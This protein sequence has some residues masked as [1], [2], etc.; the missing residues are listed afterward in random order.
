MKL[1]D[2]ISLAPQ[3]FRT[4]IN[5]AG[6][7]HRFGKFQVG[8]QRYCFTVTFLALCI[9]KVVH[10]F[11][12]RHSLTPDKFLIW[13]AT[14]FIQDALVII[15][16]RVLAQNFRRRW[17]QISTTV[18]AI[19]LRYVAET[20]FV[21]RVWNLTY[22]YS[23]PISGMASANTSFFVATGAEIHWRRVHYFHRDAAA[24]RTLLTGLAGFLFVECFIL[25]ISWFLAS[26][27]YNGMGYVLEILGS[28]LRPVLCCFRSKPVRNS[29]AYGPIP[30][31][32]YDD[33]LVEEEGSLFLLDETNG[34]PNN[35]PKSPADMIPLVK[36]LVILCPILLV[37]LLRLIRPP[38]PAYA[39]L[40]CTLPLSP[41]VAFGGPRSGPVDLTGLE[42]DYSYLSYHTA[43]DDPPFFDFLPRQKMKGFEDWSPDGH[44]HLHYNASQDPLHISNL[45]LDI[46]DPL[47][48]ALRNGSVNIRHV[49]LIK[50][51][52]TRDDVF[53]VRNGTF[54]YDRIAKSYKD[55]QI[56]KR[57]Q[58][59]L[60]NL[61]R[62]ARRLTG[63]A[64]G[65][66]PQE[67]KKAS[68]GGISA[69]NAFTVGTYTLKS[70]VGSVC[71]VNPLAADFNRE[72]KYHI[73]QPC[74]PHILD[75]LNRQPD[76]TNKTDDY[77]AWPWRSMWMQ[78][79]TDG[80]DNQKLLMRALGFKNVTT[81][82]TLR[83]RHS[84]HYPP[85]SKEIN[86]YGYPDTE[87]REYLWD[88]IQ[89]AERDHERLF[90]THLTG[91]THHPWSIPGGKYVDLLD[92]YK[93]FGVNRQ[94]NRY[95]NSIGFVDKWLGDILKM[96]EDAGVANETLLIMAGDQ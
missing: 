4:F 87:I 57:I 77:K 56:P 20:F 33:D 29:E 34:G 5:Y 55:R 19:A 11:A 95:L 59:N 93:W 49:I 23:L 2:R 10:L 91:T 74:V 70:V 64:T 80:Y 45:D 88:A 65:F 14:F 13:G 18:A 8:L 52:S 76:I 17:T 82:E 24:I 86:Y 12:H 3:T 28:S 53:P 66:D 71:G 51:E 15:F 96:L 48:E 47:Q 78:S 31:D 79:V 9:A 39:F 84:K 54:M 83:D 22:S 81:K 50:L 85:K 90:I 58:N 38:D 43:L 61:T 42:G 21:Y 26:Y 94:V 63:T 35:G 1:S 92:H 37:V 69:S 32:D 46:I 27:I 25:T 75:V 62:T 30:F 6:Y 89:A 67:D 68:Y 16:A 41:F 44:G 36:R 73:Y 60:A 7:G 40:S 72:Y